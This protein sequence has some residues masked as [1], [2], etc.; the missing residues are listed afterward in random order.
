MTW[1][2]V[3]IPGFATSK[4][5]TYGANYTNGAGYHDKLLYNQSDID[6]MIAVMGS[7]MC[8]IDHSTYTYG[9]TVVWETI[10]TVGRF[11]LNNCH[12]EAIPNTSPRAQKP[13]STSWGF[14]ILYDGENI[15]GLINNTGCDDPSDPPVLMTCAFIIDYSSQK[16]ISLLHYDGTN[17]FTQSQVT[18][19][20][21]QSHIYDILMDNII[22]YQ[23]VN[24]ITGNSKT[25]NL[26]K[27]LTINGGDPVSSAASSAVNLLTASRLDNMIDSN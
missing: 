23:A 1:E 25:Y 2:S 18:S 24:Y 15:A 8:T 14:Q 16:G 3:I 9:G 26:S 19:P 12:G 17:Y 4:M 27:I 7:Q 10:R 5:T 13:Y 20:K 22:H 21:N 11:T 6:A